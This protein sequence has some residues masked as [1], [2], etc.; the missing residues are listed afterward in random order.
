MVGALV[1]SRA[2]I[3]LRSLPRWGGAPDPRGLCATT[4]CVG[5][6]PAPSW[7]LPSAAPLRPSP[8]VTRGGAETAGPPPTCGGRFEPLGRHTPVASWTTPPCRTR[9][10]L[11][12]WPR[13]ATRSSPAGARSGRCR[14]RP[15]PGPTPAPNVMAFS[16]TSGD[17]TGFAP[18]VDGSVWGLAVSGSSVYLAGSFTTVNGVARRGVA[19]VDLATGAM[20]PRF[21]A[22]FPSGRVTEV[23]LVGGR[24]VVGGTFAKRLAALDP[25]TGARHRLPR[26]G[27]RG[28]V[29]HQRRPD[30][31]VPVL[32]RTR[33]ARG[34]SRRQLHRRWSGQARRRA[35][36]V[37]LGATTSS[38]LHPWYYRPLD[39]W[40]A[41]TSLPRTCAT[42]TSPRTAATSCWCPRATCRA[43][44]PTSARRCATRPPGSRPVSPRRRADMDR[45]HRRGH[46]AL[47]SWPPARR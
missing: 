12:R 4:L 7:P 38:D 45:L 47:P 31:R 19:K 11:A 3:W 13:P 40:C 20:D 24:L 8:P 18:S 43:P 36:M 39:R 6:A 10:G 26:P 2:R 14:T 33:P 15:G 17:L 16:A 5:H 32:G 44:A 21:D 29:G 42:S 27:D 23:R 22:R 46:P 1:L 30:R 34:W 37:T 28:G 35:F 25:T 9:S 41:A